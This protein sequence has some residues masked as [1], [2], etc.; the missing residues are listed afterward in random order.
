MTSHSNSTG[1]RDAPPDVD[2]GTRLLRGFLVGVA[3]GLTAFLTIWAPTNRPGVA[4]LIGLALL[5]VGVAISPLVIGGRHRDDA[6][7]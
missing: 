7:G 6:A 2:L 3:V 1:S 5:V 4:A